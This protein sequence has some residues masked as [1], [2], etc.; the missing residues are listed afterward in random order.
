MK[1]DKMHKLVD[2]ICEELKTFEKKV[3]NGQQLSTTE[4]QYVDTLAHA[5]KNLLKGEEMMGGY[6]SR[7]DDYSNRYDMDADS[8]YSNARGRMNARRDSMGR[9]SRSGYAMSNDTMV[10]ELRNLMHDAPDERTRKE[11]Q[12]FI[13]R[14]E[15]M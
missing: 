8:H 10:E 6:S 4:V 1:G 7:Y 11:F 13:D 14:I 15:R 12:S 2:Y 9:Y 5:K 3:G